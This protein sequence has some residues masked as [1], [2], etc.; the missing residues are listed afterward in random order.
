M[1]DLTRFSEAVIEMTEILDAREGEVGIVAFAVELRGE[2]ED[3]IV[4]YCNDER[5]WVREAFMEEALDAASVDARSE[6]G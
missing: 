6:D 2:S 5:A 4:W 1:K 3:S